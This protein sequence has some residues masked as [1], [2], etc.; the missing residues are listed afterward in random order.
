M[1]LA[2]APKGP[3]PACKRA[4]STAVKRFCLRNALRFFRMFFRLWG[5]HQIGLRSAALTYAFILALIPM[6]AVCLSAFTLFA[7]IQYLNTRFMA[8]LMEHLAP[9]S[10]KVVQS[11]I[12][13]LLGKV[14]FKK[15]GYVGFG[16]LLVVALLLLSSI[17]NAI[18]RIWSI[19]RHKELWKRVVIY[20][21][22]LILGPVSISL[23][24]ATTA[25][26]A[27]LFPQYLAKANMGSALINCV[28]L[29]LVYK[30]FPNKRVYWYAA[31]GAAVL[32][33]VSFETAKWI[34]A[35]YAA[36]AMF[37][38]K[39]YGGLAVLPLFL[40][41]VYVNWNIFLGGAL[42]SYMFQ[43]RRSF[44]VAPGKPGKKAAERRKPAAEPAPEEGKP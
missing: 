6:L 33:C 4:A 41:W 12:T 25:M 19:R 40:V 42:F 24:I 9:G 26:V 15:I 39:V 38:N 10:G 34:Y 13:N 20:N 30:I 43:H 28:L 29:T 31:F 2:E 3:T 37:Y 17:E 16:V 23:S 1:V 5:H 18:N 36:K 7:D 32:A 21:L 27:K 11:H 44:R 22:L 8:F 14:E 35:V